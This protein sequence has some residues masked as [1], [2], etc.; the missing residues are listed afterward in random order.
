[1]LKLKLSWDPPLKVGIGLQET[2]AVV[3]EATGLMQLVDV[4]RQRA[5]TVNAVVV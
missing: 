2:G 3:A 4:L 1:M 5:Y